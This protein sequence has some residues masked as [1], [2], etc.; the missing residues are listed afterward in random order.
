MV[1]CHIPLLNVPPSFCANDTLFR[2]DRRGN[3]LVIFSSIFFASPTRSESGKL[4]FFGDA[5][6]GGDLKKIRKGR[7]LEKV[8]GV[9][10]LYVD[11]DWTYNKQ[12]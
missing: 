4:T 5:L 9:I 8:N 1:P 2:T 3:V 6:Y 11:I 10:F 12:C 7:S